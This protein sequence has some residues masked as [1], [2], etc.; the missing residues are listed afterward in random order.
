MVKEGGV[1]RVQARGE[2]NAR[3]AGEEG[4]EAGTKAGGGRRR[5]EAGRRGGV[6]RGWEV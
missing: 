4:K 1:A 3:Q 5:R 2:P 6:E